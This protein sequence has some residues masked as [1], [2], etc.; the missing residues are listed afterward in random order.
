MTCIIDTDRIDKRSIP[1]KIYCSTG[2]IVLSRN[3]SQIMLTDCHG[4]KASSIPISFED[5]H[6][7]FAETESY[8]CLVFSGKVLLRINKHTLNMSVH[9]LDQSRIGRCMT[10]LSVD[11]NDILFGSKQFDRCQ[12]VKYSVEETR[13][14]LQSMSWNIDH[15]SDICKSGSNVYVVM[16]ESFV[17]SMDIATGKINGSKFV[18][19]YIDPRILSYR[20]GTIFSSQNMLNFWGK[21]NEVFVV[22]IDFDSL[23]DIYE[24]QVF[25]T[26]KQRQGLGCFDIAERKNIWT[27]DIEDISKIIMVESTDN[28]P[29]LVVTSPTKITFIDGISG[30]PLKQLPCDHPYKAIVTGKNILIHSAG[31]VT[32]IIGGL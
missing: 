31:D 24:Q 9:D 28:K 2:D 22:H 4:H 12:I 10:P 8:Y 16:N 30:I 26:T 32:E 17:V 21:T 3:H 23:E 18:A 1:Y 13:R 11:G 25:Y 20:S 5:N 19:G 29:I 14:I 7:E 15:F 27:T 6:Y